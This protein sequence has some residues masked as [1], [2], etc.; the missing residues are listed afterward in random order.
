MTPEMIEKIVENAQR[1]NA[2]V[3]IQ[4]K[5]RNTVSGT[6]I[7]GVD[8]EELKPK[9]FWRIVNESNLQEWKQTKNINLSRL[10]NGA[11][12]TKISDQ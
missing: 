1:K 11:S 4:F 12:F 8:Y 5:D 2:L 10:Y 3:R 7:Q 9:N 6:F